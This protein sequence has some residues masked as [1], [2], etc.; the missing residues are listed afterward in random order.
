V[1]AQPSD[2]RWRQADRILDEA[3]DLPP[4]ERLAFIRERCG[5]D[6]EL[7]EL[8]ERLLARCDNDDDELTPGGALAG[9]LAGALELDLERDTRLEGSRVGRYRVLRELGRGGMAMVY[10]AER[11]DGEFRQLAA[12]KLM[13]PGTDSGHMIERFHRERQILADA[14]HPNIARLLDAGVSEDG[15]PYL[16][17]EYIEGEPIDSF[18]DLRRL[19]VNQ[20]LWLFLEVA[21]AVDHA[22]RNLVVHRDIKPS[23]ILVTADGDVKLLDFGIAKLLEDGPGDVTRTHLR[24]MTPAFAS[25][26]QIEGGPITTATDIYQLGMLLYLLLAGGWPYPR[27]TGSDAAMMLAICREPPIRPST[28]AAGRGGVETVPG[29]PGSTIAEIATR[30]ATSPGRLRRELAGDLD[31]I[32]LTALRKEPQRRYGTAAQLIGDV[33]RYLEGR[34]ISARPDTVRYRLRTFVRRHT[35]ATATATASLALVVGLVAFY[36]HRVGAE[37]DHARLEASKAGEVAD[38]LTRLF[39]VSAPTRSRGESVTAR[40]LLDR[41]ADRI[42]L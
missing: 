39:Q 12:L 32:V 33:E 42:D 35:A 6:L 25:P 14:R 1:P 21:R 9:A 3:V 24:A 23:N 27:G 4:S 28:A 37:R 8:V 11:A 17:M 16:A 13:Q 15:R 2:S 7:R 38:F 26:E 36:T 22:H 40:E 5:E 29:G 31:T 20:R 18:C 10:L 19:S 30:R 41:G 34:T